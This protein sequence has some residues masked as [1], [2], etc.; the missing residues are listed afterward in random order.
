[1]HNCVLHFV[2][3]F[4]ISEHAILP[5]KVSQSQNPIARMGVQRRGAR[6]AAPETNGI[7]VS[8]DGRFVYAACGD[9]NAYAFDAET[10]QCVGTLKVRAVPF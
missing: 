3:L 1:M 2:H 10:W 7:V 8:R 9:A 4:G 5:L 6:L